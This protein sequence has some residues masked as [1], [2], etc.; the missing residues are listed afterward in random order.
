M[1]LLEDIN[2]VLDENATTLGEISDKVSE[3]VTEIQALIASGNDT[4]ALQSV[5]TKLQAQGTALAL[6]KQAAEQADA[7]LDA[8]ATPPEE[9]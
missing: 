4:P 3:V 7:D 2:T 1:T 5:L 8:E 6:L 9:A